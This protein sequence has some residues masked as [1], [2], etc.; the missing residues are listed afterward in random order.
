MSSNSSSEGG[1]RGSLLGRIPKRTIL[2]GLG[3]LA[4]FDLLF[5]FFAVRP[6]DAREAEQ[7]ALIAALQKQVEAK[8]E[9]AEK[10]RGVSGKVEQSQDDGD[11]LLVDLTLERRTTYSALLTELG[12]A[13]KESGIEIRETN[14]ESDE[15]AG[16]ERYGMVSISANFRGRYENLVKFLN[17]LDRS[18]VF[19]IIERLGAVPRQDTGDLQISMR[20]DTFVRES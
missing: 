6:L 12:E 7:Q 3:A 13:A 8:R 16:N 18:E 15:I 9:S 4:A 19:L 17:L 20:I 2:I 1:Y 14:Y 11:E 5:W 10:L